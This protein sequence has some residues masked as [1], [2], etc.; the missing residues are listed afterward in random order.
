MLQK[1]YFAQVR[2]GQVS[3]ASMARRSHFSVGGGA[4]VRGPDAIQIKRRRAR[5]QILLKAAMS[6]D[7]TSSSKA[8]IFSWRSSAETL[9]SSMTQPMRIFSTP[10][11]MGIFLYSVFQ[12]RPSISMA[13]I[14]LASSSRSVSASQGFTS[15]RIRDLA[16]GPTLAGLFLASSQASLSALLGSC[17]GTGSQR[18]AFRSCRGL[19]LP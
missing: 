15:K 18:G 3:S 16:M 6:T 2:I 14:C 7:W 13:R 4:A 10:K 1:A 12:K 5:P 11:A 9:R 19:R 17:R 8:S